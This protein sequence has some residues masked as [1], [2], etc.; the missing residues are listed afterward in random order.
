MKKLVIILVTLI[1]I[2][3][4]LFSIT[5][6]GFDFGYDKQVYGTNKESDFVTRTYNGNLAIYFYNWTGIEFNYSNMEDINTDNGEYEITEY[7][8][9]QISKQS[10]AK[11]EVWG[12][13]I[14]QA[15]ADQGSFV[16]P[17]VSFGYANQATTY[18]Y[19]VTYQGL[20]TGERLHYQI[21]AQKSKS[22]SVFAIFMLQIKLTRGLSLKGSVKSI[23]PA[24]EFNKLSDNL[25]YLV[26]LTWTF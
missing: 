1:L 19:E 22:D 12:V 16:K 24:F 10:R 17:M 13:G 15:L 6:F 7:H 5:E 3:F 4:D 14:R 21:P 11:T 9:A 26:G 20:L 23:F 8:V 18:S 2:P 25:K